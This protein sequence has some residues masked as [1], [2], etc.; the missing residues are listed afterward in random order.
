MP[1]LGGWELVVVSLLSFA[2]FICALVSIARQRTASVIARALW[3]VVC[4]IVPIL[5]PILWFA[6][7]KKSSMG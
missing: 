3:V 1:S 7:G 4:L 2:L 5:G 6:V